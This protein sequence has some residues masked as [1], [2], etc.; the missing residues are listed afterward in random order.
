MLSSAVKLF[1]QTQSLNSDCYVMISVLVQCIFSVTIISKE[2]GFW[3]QDTGLKHLMGQG[4][5]ASNFAKNLVGVL[6]WNWRT[7]TSISRPQLTF[8]E[9][10]LDLT[11]FIWTSRITEFLSEGQNQLLWFKLNDIWVYSDS[12]FYYQ[13][14]TIKN[15]WLHCSNN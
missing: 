1:F 8:G 5:L 4:D 12:T 15:F 7:I 11:N 13:F 2:S 6:N 3:W 9:Q 14:S 10:K